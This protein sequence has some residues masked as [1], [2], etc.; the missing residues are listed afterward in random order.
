MTFFEEA[1]GGREMRY[2][3]RSIVV[4]ILSLSEI[5]WHDVALAKGRKFNPDRNAIRRKFLVSFNALRFNPSSAV[6][7]R[8]SDS[9]LIKLGFSTDSRLI[10]VSSGLIDLFIRFKS[11]V[12]GI[13]GYNVDRRISRSR[14]FHLTKAHLTL[15]PAAQNSTCAI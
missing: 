12:I 7:A 15:S 3:C 9:S 13:D 8:R 5:R 14:K 6:I 4:W 2:N 10:S 11:N 1:T